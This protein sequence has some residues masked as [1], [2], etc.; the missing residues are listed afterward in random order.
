MR[1]TDVNGI[2]KAAGEYYHLVYNNVFGIRASSL[3]LTNVYGP[4]QLIKHNRQG[5]M[6][7]FIRL[8]IEDR[9]IEV[10]GD[11]S[12]VRD[13]VYVDDAV[14][15]FLIAGMCE[16]CNGEVFN[17]GGDEHI[18]HRDLVKLLV[19]LAGSGRYRF[20]EWPAEKKAID[21]G[22]FYAD[23][24]KFREATGWKP[25]I[26]LREGL[27]RTL[28]YYRDNIGRY[29]DPE[30]AGYMT[31]RFNALTPADDAAAVKEAIER[32]VGS[33]WFIL[34]PEVAA[35]ESEFASA[36]GAA[37]GV[38]VGSGTDAITLILRGLDIGPG[39]E[40][41]TSPVSAAYSAL[42]IMMAGARPVF[43]DIHPDRLTLDPAA[44]AAAVTSRTRAILPVH[45]Y[46]Q[47]ADLRCLETVAQR[48]SLAL[49]EDACQSHLAT[50]EGRP[51]GTIGV[52]GAFSFYPTKNL[53]AMGDG[54]AIVTSDAAL[55]DRVKRLR[56]GGQTAKYHHV[57]LGANSR[58][59]EMQAAILRARLPFLRRW[60]DRRRTIAAAYRDGLR[61]ARLTVPG[62]YDPGHV[63]HLFPVLSARTAGASGS[64][65]CGRRRDADSLPGSNSSST[66]AGRGPS[67]RVSN[68][69]S[70]VRT[71]AVA[72]HV[73]F[74]HR[75]CGFSSD[76][77]G[78][79]LRFLTVSIYAHSHHRRR[80]VHRLAP[81]GG[82][83]QRETSGL[84]PRRP[85][86]RVDR[87][88]LASQRPSGL[89]LHHRHGLQRLARRRN[90]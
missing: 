35:F 10:F 68:C 8:A 12:Q 7:W 27:A 45:L 90:G 79:K 36:C 18:A 61:D 66:G 39:D 83:A 46:G 55:A 63:Y 40:V 80:R 32:V 88:H 13:F 5:F 50:A 44:T 2:N 78:A 74:A 47:P 23:S 31:V 19:E 33:G 56:N 48:H 43:A 26:T 21:I 64:P 15:S 84:R 72:P 59:D 67:G 89:Q 34:G 65:G 9:E 87:Q 76:R 85:V 3:R 51:V 58:L 11:G 30:G 1:P 4:R 49:V 57:E 14:Q 25:K 60:T 22:S 6:A 29:V 20:V 86:D 54:G 82:A 52:A 62:E 77:C 42:A 16:Q 81:V 70:R 71:S 69:R 28:A 75:R 38:G 41:I 37:Y 73:S 53:G 17:I 24:S